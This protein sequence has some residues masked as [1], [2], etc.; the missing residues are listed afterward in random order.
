MTD[1]G[2]FLADPPPALVA[3][4]DDS[5]QPTVAINAAAINDWNQRVSRAG[6]M[7]LLSLASREALALGLGYF[8]VVRELT[9][10]GSPNSGIGKRH[11]EAVNSRLARHFGCISQM[12]PVPT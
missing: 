8:G 5:E 11:A 10:T 12:S 3:T 6:I 4:D 9:L 1:F 2:E 7:A